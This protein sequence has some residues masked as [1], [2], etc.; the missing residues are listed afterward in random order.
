MAV[1]NELLD[2]ATNIKMA[3]EHKNA[4]REDDSNL[5]ETKQ[6][7]QLLFD[8][9]NQLETDYSSVSILFT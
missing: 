5:N 7:G 4:E 1:K 3:D 2:N 9:T 8:D 6:N